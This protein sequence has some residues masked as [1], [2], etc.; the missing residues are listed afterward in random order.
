M[1]LDRAAAQPDAFPALQLALFSAE[2][3]D[4][5]AA[6]RHLDRAID[7]RDPCL[8]HMAVAPQ[9]D[10]LRA[11]PRFEARLSRMGLKPSQARPA[12]ASPPA[13]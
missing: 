6:L 5:D 2:A 11:D 8:V 4:L 1:V 9:W 12:A 10:R 3:G 13:P 7:S